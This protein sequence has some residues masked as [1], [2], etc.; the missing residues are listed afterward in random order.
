MKTVMSKSYRGYTANISL[1]E[2]NAIYVGL[3]EE[4]SESFRGKTVDEALKRFHA[5]VDRHIIHGA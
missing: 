3:V 4:I 1:D 2:D 5:V